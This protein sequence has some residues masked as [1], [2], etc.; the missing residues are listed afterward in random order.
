V[1]SNAEV[2]SINRRKFLTVGGTSLLTAA[3]V[4]ACGGSTG[5]ASPPPSTSSTTMAAQ[6]DVTILRTASS[7]EQVAID[8]YT[9]ALASNVIKTTAISDA[10][11]LFQSHHQDHA[12]LLHG[13]TTDAGGQPYTQANSLIMSTVVTPGL[14][15]VRTEA[16]LVKL[17]FD[18]EKLAA[19]TYQ[20]DV[21]TF[22]NTLYN[23]VVMSIGGVEAKHVAVLFHLLG[24]P[25][26]TT[27]GAFQKT[28]GA[29]ASGSG[30]GG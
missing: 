2:V 28:D 16:D 27:D 8:A 4:A 23:P 1:D 30:L 17:A 18:L 25:N 11:T 15:A 26:L 20:S 5:S 9:Q 19:A 13:K 10:F 3:V 12:T 24:Q 14:A 6:S 22:Q 7:I 21:G 29:V